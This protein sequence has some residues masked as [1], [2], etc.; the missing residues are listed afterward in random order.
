M[1]W[2]Q[3]HSEPQ[4]QTVTTAPG[5]FQGPH[6]VQGLCPPNS[7]HCLLVAGTSCPGTVFLGSSGPGHKLLPSRAAEQTGAPGS[8]GWVAGRAP[9]SCFLRR[10]GHPVGRPAG[11]QGDHCPTLPPTKGLPKD[12]PPVPTTGVLG[13]AGR[14]VT[15]PPPLG[16]AGR[17]WRCSEPGGHRAASS[18][19]WHESNPRVFGSHG[20]PHTGHLTAI[21]DK[22]ERPSEGLLL[23]GPRA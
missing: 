5:F 7:S 9:A 20:G 15:P 11:G 1:R 21:D 22:R 4:S 6:H 10:P 3:K 18:L 14:R 2:I 17:V 8:W 19:S 23:F 12:R 13:Q 16:R